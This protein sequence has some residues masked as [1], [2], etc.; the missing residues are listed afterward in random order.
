[1][2]DERVSRHGKDGPVQPLRMASGHRFL[3]TT[4]NP[5][6]NPGAPQKAGCNL[7]LS[8]RLVG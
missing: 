6:L 4:L 1:M 5:G 3:N 8:I 7:T 2:F